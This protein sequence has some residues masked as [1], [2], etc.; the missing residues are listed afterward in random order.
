MDSSSIRLNPF[1]SLAKLCE[2][3]LSFTLRKGYNM[4]RER[5]IEKGDPT[6]MQYPPLLTNL[7]SVFIFFLSFFS[8]L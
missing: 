3:L 7:S 5:K 4:E 2:L 6:V 8:L 1:L